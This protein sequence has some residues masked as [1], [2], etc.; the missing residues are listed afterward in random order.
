MRIRPMTQDDVLPVA[1]M[2]RANAHSPWSYA[3]IQ[4]EVCLQSY[5]RI[6]EDASGLCMGYLM[7]RLQFD[8]WHVLLL[9]IAPPFRRRGGA[10]RLL[11]D[12][13]HQATTEGHRAISLEVRAS[14]TPART[15]YQDMGFNFLYTRRAYYTLGLETE[16]AIVLDFSCVKQTVKKKRK[17]EKT[18]A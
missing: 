16:D 11:G 13:I 15:L 9:G 7:A 6:L 1:E 2:E 14:N 5:G 10:K 12:L 3:M 4:D 8:V 18:S 17:K